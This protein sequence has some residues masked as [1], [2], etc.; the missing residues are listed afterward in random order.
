MITER[1]SVPS[2]WFD[3]QRQ[4]EPD[5][6]EQHEDVD[7]VRAAR[8]AGQPAPGQEREEQQQQHP[9]R[10]QLGAGEREVAGDQQAGDDR[11]QE[12]GRGDGG[13]GEHAGSAGVDG[14]SRA[15]LGCRAVTR[16][17]E[18]RLRLLDHRPRPTRPGRARA[19]LHRRRSPR[20]A[21]LYLIRWPDPVVSQPFPDSGSYR[22]SAARSIAGSRRPLR[23]R[24][25]SRAPVNRGA[26]RRGAGLAGARRIPDPAVGYCRMPGKAPTRS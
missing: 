17:W 24:G 26:R 18:G 5:R 1:G 15:G 14:G 12:P 4:P 19:H 6:A 11:E 9:V 23:S 8:L 2:P 10:R 13:L 25:K 7:G 3:G 16:S 20:P 22:V 21:L